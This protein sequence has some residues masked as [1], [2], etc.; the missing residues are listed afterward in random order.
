M[1]VT[2]K[3]YPELYEA[4][5]EK[6]LLRQYDLLTNFIEIGLHQG[7]QAI[8]KYMLWA[9]NHA[10]V[11]GISQFGGRFRE[12]P[13][14]VGNHIPPHFDNVPDLM[15]RFLSFIHENWDNLSP[16]QLAGYG[17]W[18]L[19]WIHPFVEGNGR[20]ARA[21]CYYLLCVRSGSLLP[22]RKIV[23]ERIRENRHPYYDALRNT[24]KH[25]ADGNLE[26]QFMESYMADLLLAQ[27]LDED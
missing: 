16:T 10:A 4:L 9:L 5:L 19:N 1:L 25:W 8:D 7:P 13:I 17:L 27:L 23:P 20:T 26:L 24:D 21:V 12:E 2:E 14:Y 11:A 22:G 3:Q 15:D 18:R 6:N